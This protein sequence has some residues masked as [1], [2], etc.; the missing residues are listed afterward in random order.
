LT[1]I[2]LH[3][4]WVKTDMGGEKAPVDVATSVT[5]MR[6]VIASSN[7]NQNGE[8]FNYDGSVIPW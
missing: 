8:F 6:S 3:P 1:T 7:I 5:G 2:L 4:G